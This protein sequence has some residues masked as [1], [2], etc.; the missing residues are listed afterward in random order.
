[1]R[2]WS[3][4]VC[5][6]YH[7][8]ATATR[9][10]W[11]GYRCRGSFDRPASLRIPDDQAS[12]P[13][14]LAGGAIDTVHRKA[15]L[16]P[17]SALRPGSVFGGA[18]RQRSAVHVLQAAPPEGRNYCRRITKKAAA[19]FTLRTA[20]FSK[21]DRRRNPPAAQ[22]KMRHETTTRPK[23]ARRRRTRGAKN[24][25][26][27]HTEP[28]LRPARIA[29]AALAEPLKHLAA[30]RGR[31]ARRCH[32]CRRG[33]ALPPGISRHHASPDCEPKSSPAL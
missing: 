24:P 6:S 12:N 31:F 29:H 30:P 11:P 33:L 2:L 20:V 19:G 18:H 9:K 32:C 26:L 14:R 17:F 13:V 15:R 28:R 27:S 3:G 7:A 1:M 8:I 23:A 22:H 16:C 21:F 10:C 4:A 25:R 5:C